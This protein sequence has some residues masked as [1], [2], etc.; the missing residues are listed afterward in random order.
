MDRLDTREGNSIHSVYPCFF[1][2]VVSGGEGCPPR[3]YSTHRRPTA[4][5]DNY[6]GQKLRGKKLGKWNMAR[7]SYRPSA[8]SPSWPNS[9]LMIRLVDFEEHGFT[10]GEHGA[11]P[12]LNRPPQI[13]L[14]SFPSLE[15]CQAQQDARRP[16][17]LLVVRLQVWSGPTRQHQLELISQSTSSVTVTVPSPPCQGDATLESRKRVANHTRHGERGGGGSSRRPDTHRQ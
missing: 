11:L 13:D 8:T 7:T 9:E 15:L 3:Y 10:G 14:V 4:R 16:D 5:S 12:I 2:G 6:L 17:W 1:P